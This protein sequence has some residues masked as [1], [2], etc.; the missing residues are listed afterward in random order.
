MQNT[1]VLIT[2]CDH[3]LAKEAINLC[4]SYFRRVNVFDEND[5]FV[6]E[7]SA[8]ARGCDLLVSFLN[9]SILPAAML[10]YPNINFHPGPPEYPGRGGASYALYDGATKYGATAHTM[11]E[12]V[13]A[14]S[15]LLV[16]EFETAPY[17]RCET[18]FARAELSCMK[19]LAE[20]LYIFSTAGK[21]PPPNGRTWRGK[22]GTRKQFVAWLNLDAA[23][24]TVFRRKVAA[25]YHSKFPGPYV[26]VHGLKFGLVKDEENIAALDRSLP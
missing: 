1:C 17:K 12:Q 7:G 5:Q 22:P 11:A 20:A 2:D 18:L 19:L 9:E 4:K 15:I 6:A 24:P 13:D 23:H 3:Y 25:A 26:L 21:L 10:R 14:G 16:D 8:V